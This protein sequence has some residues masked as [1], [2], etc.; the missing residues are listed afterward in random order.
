MDSERVG[1]PRK[2]ILAE[3]AKEAV[4]TQSSK[5]VRPAAHAAHT[6]SSLTRA[7]SSLTAHTGFGPFGSTSLTCFILH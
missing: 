2:R 1:G 3:K 5:W 6:P 4:L 7:P